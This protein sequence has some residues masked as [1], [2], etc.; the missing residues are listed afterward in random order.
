MAR[1]SY[2]VGGRDRTGTIKRGFWI[3][4][5]KTMLG[6]FAARGDRELALSLRCRA[7]YAALLARPEAAARRF[8]V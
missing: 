7:T 8:L 3:F 6:G 1:R 4:T 5:K 2:V